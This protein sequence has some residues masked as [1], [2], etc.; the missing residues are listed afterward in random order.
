M[1]RAPKFG[2]EQ[3]EGDLV[4]IPARGGFGLVIVRPAIRASSSARWASTGL[5]AAPGQRIVDRGRVHRRQPRSAA[6]SSPQGVFEGVADHVG[7]ALFDQALG[8]RR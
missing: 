5:A 6:A 7:V 3:L 4:G 8:Q 2:L 1:G